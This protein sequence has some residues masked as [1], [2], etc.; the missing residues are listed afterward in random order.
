MFFPDK[1]PNMVKRFKA[2]IKE[3]VYNGTVFHRIMPGFMIQGGDPNSKDDD[4]GNDG[5]GG[6]G[7]M[8]KAEFNDVKHVP[9]IL[10][11]ARTN[12]PDTAQS[13]FFIV[14]GDASFLDGQYTVFG[15]VL[16]GLKVVDT[17]VNLPSTGNQGDPNHPNMPPNYPLPPNVPKILKAELVK[18][19]LK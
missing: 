12:E 11:T 9:G 17:I 15:K 4:P 3:G 16:E 10:S 7:E 1:A 18:W 8:L 19:P 13:Q 2:A 5:S 6:W 14:H